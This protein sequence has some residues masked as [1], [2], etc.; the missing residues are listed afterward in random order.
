MGNLATETSTRSS[1]AREAERR[2]EIPESSIQRILHGMLDL[3][4]YKI[5]ALHQL[6]PADTDA[7]QNFSTWERAQMERNPH[8]LLNVM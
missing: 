4:L 1:S 2:T 8:W 6:L 7:R 5:R 3:C